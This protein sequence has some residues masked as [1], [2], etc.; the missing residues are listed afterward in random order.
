M[1]AT[2]R[3]RVS[4]RFADL[5]SILMHDIVTRQFD[6]ERCYRS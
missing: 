2:G 4:L 5:M 1:H 3:Q 6:I